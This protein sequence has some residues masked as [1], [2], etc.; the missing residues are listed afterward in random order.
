[1]NA[2]QYRTA[3]DHPLLHIKK[4]L[5]NR[6]KN[7]KIPVG[8]YRDIVGF[9]MK[10]PGGGYGNFENFFLSFASDFFYVR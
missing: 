10:R 1:M 4:S 5:E 2:I 8:G 9:Y 6:K 7:S 3:C